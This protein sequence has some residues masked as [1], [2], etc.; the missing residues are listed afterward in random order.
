M[1]K[2]DLSPS[3]ATPLQMTNI[4]T[5]KLLRKDWCFGQ[6]WINWFTPI[7]LH[8]LMLPLISYS[9]DIFQKGNENDLLEAEQKICMPYF[10]MNKKLFSY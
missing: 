1:V 7:K 9:A 10:K 8:D 5:I 2:T 4:I 3:I 6:T